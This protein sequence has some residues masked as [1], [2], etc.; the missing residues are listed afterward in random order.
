MYRKLGIG[1]VSL[2][3][4][5][6]L[7]VTVFAQDTT[8]DEGKIRTGIQRVIDEGFN[9]GN[10][11]VVDDGYTD[12][13]VIHPDNGN[14]ESFKN[15]ITALRK[16]MPE[17]KAGVEMV[18][19]QGCDAFFLFHFHGIMQN[20]L[21]AP[22]QQ[23]IPPSGNFLDLDAHIYLHFNA[24]AQVVEEW[25]YADNL[26]LLTQTGVIPMAGGE[27][28]A[29][30]EPNMEAT[31]AAMTETHITMSGNEARNADVVHRAYE[32]GFN[33]GSVDTLRTLYTADYVSH[34]VD[35]ST[36]GLDQ[37]FSDMTTLRSAIPDAKITINGTVA[38]GD[39]VATR[40]TFTGT[41]QKPLAFSGQPSLPP[42]GKP[43]TLEMS[44]VH[45]LSPDGK[46][47]E[48]WE[49]YDQLV[50]LTQLGALQMPAE[51][52]QQAG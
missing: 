17:G 40:V 37:F 9:K 41:F 39:A 18:L 38:E 51:A 50:F 31:E 15:S 25:D 47:A 5:L 27:A 2:L 28:N 33:T 3:L 32:Q 8:C 11:S 16:A 21:E 48:D 24:Q 43:I 26:S 30:A 36:S 12:T 29:T 19:V 34:G 52:T 46:I 7:H 44:F 14:R 4:V 49:T 45:R 1:L 10:L 23:P 6:G 20:A 35:H 42:T 22:R 13:A